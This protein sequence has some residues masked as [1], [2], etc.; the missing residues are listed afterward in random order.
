MLVRNG[1]VGD[2]RLGDEDF[3][4]SF[5]LPTQAEKRETLMEQHPFPREKRSVF[6]E[7]PHTYTVDDTQVGPRSVTGVLHQFVNAFDADVALAEMRARNTWVW[8]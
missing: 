1:C 5:R 7:A 4:A 8:K 6:D 3:M 2:W